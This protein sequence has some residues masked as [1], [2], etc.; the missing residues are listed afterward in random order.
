MTYRRDKLK[1]QVFVNM[2]S[3]FVKPLSLTS[4]QYFIKTIKRGRDTQNYTSDITLHKSTTIWVTL[5]TQTCRCVA[6]DRDRVRR[7]IDIKIIF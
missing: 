6:R 3:L 7:S 5:W 1:L 4:R 2:S